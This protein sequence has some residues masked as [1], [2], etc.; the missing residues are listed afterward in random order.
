MQTN[1]VPFDCRLTGAGEFPLMA[2]DLGAANP[3]FGQPGSNRKVQHPEKEHRKR[4]PRQREYY[5]L[6][7]IE[8]ILLRL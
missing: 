7:G 1:N 3:E 6:D 8:R 4:E 2:V 5:L